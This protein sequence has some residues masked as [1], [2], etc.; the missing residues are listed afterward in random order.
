MVGSIGCAWHRALCPE[1]F[2]TKERSRPAAPTSLWPERATRGLEPALQ[3]ELVLYTHDRGR[4]W[5][6]ADT[7]LIAGPSAG[8]FSVA[9]RDAK[10]GV[11]VGGDYKNEKEA[12][13]NLAFTNDGGAT[14]TLVKG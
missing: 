8:I 5:A 13:D 2:R 3:Q 7:P 4:T 10:H 11:I 9:F 12:L 14:W 1:R 6:I